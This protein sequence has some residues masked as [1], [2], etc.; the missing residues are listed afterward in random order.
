M[1]RAAAASDESDS[2]CEFRFRTAALW[3]CYFGPSA[4]R[5]R[6]FL[7]KHRDADGQIAAD[8]FPVRRASRHPHGRV[9]ADE[10]A[11]EAEVSDSDPG[12][13]INERYET[14]F[15]IIL[16]EWTIE[17]ANSRE[18]N[19]RASYQRVNGH[20]IYGHTRNSRGCRN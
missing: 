7:D 2:N 3:R 16:I 4:E 9:D 20:V 1:E 13:R 19:E 12:F 17:M 15:A 18:Y 8:A 6:P 11:V 10:K 14:E 5:G